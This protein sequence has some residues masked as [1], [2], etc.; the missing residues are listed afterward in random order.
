[1]SLM[2][3]PARGTLRQCRKR[4]GTGLRLTRP[5]TRKLRFASLALLFPV[6]ACGKTDRDLELAEEARSAVLEM[7]AVPVSAHFDDRDLYVNGDAGLVCGGMVSARSAQG[8]DVFAR[9]YF[10]QVGRGA[11]VEDGG[12]AFL[13]G[14]PA[15]SSAASAR[16]ESPDQLLRHLMDACKREVG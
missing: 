1:M 3:R 10:Y 6:V 16:D 5:T 7:L 9:R 14:P 2:S 13:R 4:P 8:R 12:R 15:N 11:A